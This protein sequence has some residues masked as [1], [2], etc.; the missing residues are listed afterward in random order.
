MVLLLSGCAVVHYN[1]GDGSYGRIVLK[2]EVAGCWHVV[3][4]YVDVIVALVN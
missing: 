3:F 2:R 4:G 1:Y